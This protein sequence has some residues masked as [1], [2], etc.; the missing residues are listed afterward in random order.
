M[1]KTFFLRFVMRDAE[2]DLIY[3]V[4]EEE[5]D[6]LR[7]VLHENHRLDE[8]R[9]FWFETLKGISV[10]VNLAYVQGVR[11][12]WDPV[13]S[14]PNQL[15]SE[16]G[17]RIQFRGRSEP[18]EEDTEDPDLLFDLF[19]NLQHGPDVVAAPSFDDEDG[20]SSF[21]NPHELVW[22]S[23]PTHILKEGERMVMEED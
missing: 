21:I 9:F 1:T 13:E 2:Q 23:A 11:P 20:E 10:A 17:I 19:V 16:E 8:T 6:R 4:R 18:L 5:S 22:I 14:A 7:K 12:S 3:Q 15:R